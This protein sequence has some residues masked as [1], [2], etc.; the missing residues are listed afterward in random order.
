MASDNSTRV[1]LVISSTHS[2]R[3]FLAGASNDANLSLE[4][5]QTSSDLLLQSDIPYAPLRAVWMASDPSSRPDLSR[6]FAGTQ[7]VFSSPKPREKVSYPT[8]ISSLF[9]RS[10]LPL[11]F[12][13]ILCLQNVFLIM[14]FTLKRIFSFIF[15]YFSGF[16]IFSW[17]I[18]WLRFILPD[19]FLFYFN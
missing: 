9:L 12:F 11:S 17:Y 13:L 14:F 3:T 1:G 6:L 5:R 2:I 18:D 15:C 7:F 19:S 16:R 4:L 8:F 10:W